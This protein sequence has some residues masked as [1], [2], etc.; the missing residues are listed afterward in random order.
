MSQNL[1]DRIDVDYADGSGEAPDD[2][3]HVNDKIEKAVEV[4]RQGLEEY[5]NPAVMWTGGKDSTLVL[6]F[7]TQV[8]EQHDLE[9]PPA[10]FIDHYQHFDEIHDFVDHWADQWGLEV[11]YARNED[12]GEY[13]A[14]HDL[15]PGD[16][17]EISEL[18]EHNRHHVRDILEYE[19]DT[20]PFLLDTYVGNHLLKTVA[21]NDAI[22]EYGTD[23]I[24]SGVR[25]DEQEAR[26]DE[27]FFSPRH[28][29]DIH[30]PHDRVQPILQ[31]NEA[32][33]WETFWNFVVPDTVD[34]FPDDG[35]VP[36]GKDDLPDDLDP[37]D[38]PVSPKYWEGFRSLGSE[39]STEKTE[40][41]PAWLQDLEGTTERAGRAQDKEDLMERLR[42]LG[43]M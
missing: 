38:T 3:P 25:W 2:Y 6:Y 39:I 23:G 7:V 43:Y 1:S 18:S 37:F 36:E 10:I 19:E 31:F 17:I 28:D 27:T 26:A 16:E 35:Y 21:L 15:D 41:D 22:E 30:P 5:D 20:F 13:V 34:E 40:T 33:V 42:D 24:V 4:T 14:D 11:I 29:P 9:V 32:A 12:V 8:A